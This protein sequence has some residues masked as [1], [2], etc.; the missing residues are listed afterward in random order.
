M[1]LFIS[2]CCLVSAAILASVSQKFDRYLHIFEVLSGLL[3]IIGLAVT[4]W[5]LRIKI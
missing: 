4:G 5:Y 3:L 1:A 2:A